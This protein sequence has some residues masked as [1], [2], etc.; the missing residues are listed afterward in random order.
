MGWD[1]KQLTV[2]AYVSR[3]NSPQDR[4]DDKAWDELRAA[5]VKLCAQEKYR[6]I[7]VDIL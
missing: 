7:E 4:K 5:I 2:V 1:R 6:E 3:H